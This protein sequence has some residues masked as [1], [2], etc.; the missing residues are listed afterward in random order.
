MEEIEEIMDDEDEKIYN[1]PYIAGIR[2]VERMA[3]HFNFNHTVFEL[4]ISTTVVNVTGYTQTNSNT[5]D[6]WPHNIDVNVCP[7]LLMPLLHTI[8]SE[9][10]DNYDMTTKTKECMSGYKVKAARTCAITTYDR[11]AQAINWNSVD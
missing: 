9:L 2:V 8:R 4:D 3:S 6:V 5:I 1:D 11:L 7:K 10:R